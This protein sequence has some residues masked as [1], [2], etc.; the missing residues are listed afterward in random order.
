MD[1]GRRMSVSIRRCGICDQELA[2]NATHLA[3][4]QNGAQGEGSSVQVLL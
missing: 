1:I 4:A 3:A 2:D